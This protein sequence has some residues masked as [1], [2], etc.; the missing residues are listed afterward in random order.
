MTTRTAPIG[1]RV[2]ALA[3]LS[4]LGFGIYFICWRGPITIPGC[5]RC[6]SRGSPT[7]RS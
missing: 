6:S 4:G 1:L 2:L 3:C 7:P 5:G